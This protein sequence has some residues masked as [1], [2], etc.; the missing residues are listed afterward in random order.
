M[1]GLLIQYLILAVL[2]LFLMAVAF[3]MCCSPCRCC[4]RRQRYAPSDVDI[5]LQQQQINKEFCTPL[6]M[7]QQQPITAPITASTFQLANSE[8]SE[9]SELSGLLADDVTRTPI[10]NDFAG[11]ST[12]A[13]T[14]LGPCDDDDD[15]DGEG[16]LDDGIAPSAAADDVN[17]FPG[18]FIIHFTTRIFQ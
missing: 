10:S 8:A 5:E 11:A 13:I 12:A 4:R 16:N 15:D 1:G 7:D 17:Y 2:A 14:S 18:N 9:N 3:Y 6:L